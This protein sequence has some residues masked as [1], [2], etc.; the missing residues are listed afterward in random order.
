MA[1]W[2]ADDGTSINYETTGSAAHKETL[3]LLPSMLGSI[4]T[5]WR[6][7]VRPLSADFNIV[8]MDLRGHGRSDNKTNELRPDRMAKDIT[9]LIDHLKINRLHVAGYSLG[10]YLGLILALNLPRR[11]DSLFIHATK[12]YWSKEAAGN[13]QAQLDPD[14]MAKKVPAYADQLVQLHGA[15]HW[16]ELVRQAA[17]L[18]NFLVTNGLTD[19]MVSRIQTPVLVSV[20]DHDEMVPL[21]EAARLSRVIPNSGLFVMPNVRHP[22][23]TIKPVP[24]IPMIQHFHQSATQK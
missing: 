23:T 1:I 20:G 13:M 10:G 12:F 5:E 14:Q 18:V 4:T 22:F 24:F 16:R 21:P 19:N 2:K 15:R 17:D 8:M 3:L 6:N 7:F 11:V 9:G